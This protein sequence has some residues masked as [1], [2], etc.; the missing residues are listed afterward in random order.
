[1]TSITNTIEAAHL[2]A[3]NL[4]HFGMTPMWLRPISKQPKE[5]GW[6]SKPRPAL[7]ELLDN[8]G[9]G[10]N[11]AVRTGR[12]S[13][14]KGG[15]A[16]GVLDV[17]LKSPEQCHIDEL[18]T[19]LA[20]LLPNPE[21]Y[22]CVLSGR[23]NGSRHYW[24]GVEVGH[25]PPT[26]YLAKSK[27]KVG[28]TG[29]HAWE[30]QWI[31]ESKGG[32]A[33]NIVCPPSVHPDTGER[34]I[35][36]NEFTGALP[37]IPE[38]ILL[39][40]NEQL[41]TSQA[42]TYEPLDGDLS[43]DQLD[44]PKWLFNLIKDGK[45]LD[46]YG[47]RSEAL[48][49][50]MK[51]LI[52][53]KANDES[54]ASILTNPH[55]VLADKALSKFSSEDDS[56]QWIL[57]QVTKLRIEMAVA[58]ES[59]EIGHGKRSFDQYCIDDLDELG[60]PAA[61]DFLV[62]NMIVR[63]EF[64]VIYADPNVGKT[65][66][67]V[68]SLI[69]AVEAGTIRGDQVI[70]INADDSSH[71]AALKGRLLIQYGIR[72]II[73]SYQNFSVDDLEKTMVDESDNGRAKGRVII[74]DTLTQFAD[75][76]DVKQSRQFA[77]TARRFVMAGGSIVVLAHT[78]KDRDLSGNPVYRGT[79]DIRD[80]CDCSI[81]AKVE[82]DGSTR[83]VCFKSD[84]VRGGGHREVRFQYD[85]GKDLDY[86]ERL[87]SLREL[88]EEQAEVDNQFR[89]YQRQ[90]VIDKPTIE[91]MIE[92]LEHGPLQKTDFSKRTKDK[93]GASRSNVLRIVEN[94]E[95]SRC[96]LSGFWVCTNTGANN[97]MVYTLSDSVDNLINQL[98]Q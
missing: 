74:V 71:G 52:K 40:L 54:I 28:D 63:G 80:S 46:K 89:S 22:P 68:K 29:K 98:N 1:M 14:C 16:L 55:H 20:K 8:Y 70:Y 51:E 60:E 47:T 85:N 9:D 82:E 90:L 19:A 79:T 59:S 10:D 77:K 26:A 83:T 76:V 75:A 12:I 2:A 11:L 44:L 56:K 5:S 36:E 24:M 7:L 27:D 84:K 38:T 45:G 35:W 31:S 81:I 43:L 37:M 61:L 73:P 96:G 94:Y 39:K 95:V 32:N 34:Y 42:D 33:M 57:K 93:S 62:P 86:T 17:D 18:R 50:V 41:I 92:I 66:V 67:I 65:L 53:A 30:I 13:T 58:T 91:V 88:T 3:T 6:N 4:H 69:N 25:V 87:S 15:L 21:S 49:A 48:Y 97:A 72:T 23:A 64:S 78:K